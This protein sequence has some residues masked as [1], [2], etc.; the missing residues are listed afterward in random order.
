MLTARQPESAVETVTRRSWRMLDVDRFRAA[1]L[2]SRLCNP[3]FWQGLVA[4]AMALLYDTEMT[5]VLDRLV[6]VGTI[7][8]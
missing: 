1:L 2:S 3:E 6:P 7:Q 8:R 5:A 4:D